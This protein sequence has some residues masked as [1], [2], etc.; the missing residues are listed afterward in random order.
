MPS[1]AI[2]DTAGQHDHAALIQ[3]LSTLRGRENAASHQQS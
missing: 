3:Y 1:F 2:V